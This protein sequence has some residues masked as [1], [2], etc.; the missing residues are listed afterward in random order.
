MDS[1][2]IPYGR[3]NITQEDL[4]AVA[5]TLKSDWLTQ[6]PAI[7]RFEKAMAE[8]CGA[9]YAVAVSNATAAL[10]L[11][12][13]AAG[14]KNGETVLTSPNTFVATANAALYCGAKPAFVDIDSSTLNLDTAKLASALAR[15]KAKIVA[16]VHF[17]G[18]SCDM[19]EIARLRDR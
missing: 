15:T 7:E 8:Y 9:R 10:H 13:L 16:P 2:H 17:G 1:N 4:E 6:G 3:Q 11:A 14:L 5:A 19:K 12:Y 18:L